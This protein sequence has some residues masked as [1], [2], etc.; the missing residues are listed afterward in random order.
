MLVHRN[1]GDVVQTTMRDSE[2]RALLYV[3][4]S[5]RH[6]KLAINFQKHAAYYMYHSGVF[7]EPSTICSF[8]SPYVDG[9]MY[10]RVC[11]IEVR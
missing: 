4:L 8:A 1:V 6:S 2:M 5:S 10:R 3:V 11:M 9:H 7:L